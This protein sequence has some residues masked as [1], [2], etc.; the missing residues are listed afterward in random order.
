MLR[1][2][3]LSALLAVAALGTFS[4]A[5]SAAPA[6]NLSSNG[7]AALINVRGGG[8]G[9]GGVH[10]GGGGHSGGGGH[11]GG[12]HYGRGHGFHGGRFAFAPYFGGYYD[13]YAYGPDC[14]YSRARHRWVC[15]AY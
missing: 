15:P 13:D 1:S 7:T 10:F 8:G 6:T 3:T 2:S 5:A 9:G 14:W 11:N 4:A 12:G